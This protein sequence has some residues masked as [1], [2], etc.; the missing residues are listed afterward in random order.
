ME[1]IIKE[2][3]IMNNVSPGPVLTNFRSSYPVYSRIALLIAGYFM[4]KQ[5]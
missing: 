4:N 1:Q 3:A 5:K 2:L